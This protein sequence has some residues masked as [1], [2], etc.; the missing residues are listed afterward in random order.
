VKLFNNLSF[1]SRIGL[2]MLLS[3]AL[4]LTSGYLLKRK[5]SEKEFILEVEVDYGISSTMEMHF[6]TGRDFNG[7]QEVVG[8]I[9]KGENKAHFPFKIE[10]GGPLK[11]LRLDFGN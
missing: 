4:N 3:L 8:V 11:F 7:V 10:E 2:A 9:R 6:D 1:V 5:L